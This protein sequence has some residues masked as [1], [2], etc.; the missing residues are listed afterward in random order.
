M[1]ELTPKQEELLLEQAIEERRDRLEEL[2][3]HKC[4]CCNNYF[5]EEELKF[6]LDD[7]SVCES[8]FE[9]TKDFN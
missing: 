7:I 5:N 9:E 1:E 2:G 3:L 8:C 4:G 6:K